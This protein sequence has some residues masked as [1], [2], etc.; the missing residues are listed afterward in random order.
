M[1]EPAQTPIE[2]KAQGAP[3][4]NA[5]LVHARGETCALLSVDLHSKYCQVLSW[6]GESVFVGASE[7]SLH[8]DE[9]QPREAPTEIAF[10]EFAG[11]RVWCADLGRYTLSLALIKETE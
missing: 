2:I 3:R 6:G 7:R 10:P 9:S 4:I 1:S 5:A 11:W 8:L